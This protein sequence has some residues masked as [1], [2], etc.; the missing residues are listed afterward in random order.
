MRAPVICTARD[1]T[2]GLL[3]ARAEPAAA[4]P[5]QPMGL[6]AGA[7]RALPPA[8]GERAAAAAVERTLWPAGLAAGRESPPARA[9][10]LASPRAL[11]RASLPMMAPL[12]P[13]PWAR[14]SPVALELASPPAPGRASLPTMALLSPLAPPGR[15][16]PPMAGRES[17]RT[18]ERALPLMVGLASPPASGRASLPTM[19]LLSPPAPGRA[20]P[21]MAGLESPLAPERASPPAA[22]GLAP[23]S[24]P[25]LGPGLPPMLGPPSPLA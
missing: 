1:T 8:A 23:L 12:S 20:L 19:A 10:E 9:L 2:N 18:P 24:P 15:A 4:G 14:A 5:E 16:L 13:A 6:S 3:T 17:P 25:A 7:G 22:Q 21:P 11:E